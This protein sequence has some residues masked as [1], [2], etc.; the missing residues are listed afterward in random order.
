[1]A[2][3]CPELMAAEHE[4][5]DVASVL[6]FVIDSETRA[7][8]SMLEVAYLISQGK[9]IILVI[10]DLPRSGHVILGEPITPW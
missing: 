7:V 5:K 1:M 8:A 9:N 2:S 4:A 3:W 6:F 10:T